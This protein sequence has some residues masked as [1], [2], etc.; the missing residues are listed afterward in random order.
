MIV[1]TL[2]R[3]HYIEFVKPHVKLCYDYSESNQY[4]FEEKIIYFISR[5]QWVTSLSLQFV[6]RQHAVTP[7]YKHVHVYTRGLH[8]VISEKCYFT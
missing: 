2:H 5:Q 8:Y 4:L 6:T 7:W 3:F 1:S